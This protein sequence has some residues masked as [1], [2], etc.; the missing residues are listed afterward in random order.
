MGLSYERKGNPRL[1][2]FKSVPRPLEE[3]MLFVFSSDISSPNVI[4][5]TTKRIPRYIR[6]GRVTFSVANMGFLGIGSW[7]IGMNVWAPVGACWGIGC[8]VIVGGGPGSWCMSFTLES[9]Q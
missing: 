9:K 3:K 5:S 1:G 8:I 2:A 7:P 6:R 4:V